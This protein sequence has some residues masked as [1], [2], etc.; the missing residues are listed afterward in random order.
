MPDQF[1][2]AA[3]YADRI[4]K[5]SKPAD[6]PVQAPAYDALMEARAA[7]AE[8]EW[9][10]ALD[11]IVRALLDPSSEKVEAGRNAFERLH[12]PRSGPRSHRR[13]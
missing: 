6:L 13:T 5:G 9:Q 7:V 8:P 11:A 3:D 2:R 10:A 4:F 1:R 12:R